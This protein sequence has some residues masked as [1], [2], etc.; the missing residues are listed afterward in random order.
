MKNL[1]SKIRGRLHGMGDAGLST[2]E[3]ITISVVLL[4]LAIAVGAAITNYVNSQLPGL[5]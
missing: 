5:G 1:L 4:G 3:V 2:L